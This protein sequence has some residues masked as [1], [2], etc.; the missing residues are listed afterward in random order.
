M[1]YIMTEVIGTLYFLGFSTVLFS[2]LSFFCSY[3]WLFYKQKVKVAEENLRL[4]S[5]QFE[6]EKKKKSAKISDSE[7]LRLFLN[8]ATKDEGILH[9][10][11]LNPQDMYFHRR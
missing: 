6:E 8:D 1:G 5:M 3:K 4:L 2:G 11:Y 9:I 7:A 10:S